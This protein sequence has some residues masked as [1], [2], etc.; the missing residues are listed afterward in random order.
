MAEIIPLE[1]LDLIK[2]GLR[3]NYISEYLKYTDSLENDD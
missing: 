3:L 2:S 1:Y